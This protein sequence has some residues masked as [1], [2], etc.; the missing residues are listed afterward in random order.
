VHF[1]D[2]LAQKTTCFARMQ[3]KRIAVHQAV[4]GGLFMFVSIVAPRFMQ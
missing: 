4:R 2:P 3:G 1:K